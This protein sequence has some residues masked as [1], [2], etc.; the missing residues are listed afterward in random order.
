MEGTLP[1][2]SGGKGSQW[3]GLHHVHNPEGWTHCHR[4]ER[5]TVSGPKINMLCPSQTFI[6]QTS[7][8]LQSSSYSSF[9]V[10]IPS[11]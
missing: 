4:G 3:S 7:D 10:L 2:A 11:D 8:S 9:T 1:G 5:A 6:M